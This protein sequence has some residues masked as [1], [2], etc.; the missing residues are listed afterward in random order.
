LRTSLIIVGTPVLVPAI[1][2]LCYKVALR[3][4]FFPLGVK[5]VYTIRTDI[6]K[7]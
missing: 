2:T 1:V 7:G 5:I 3:A 4:P 6:V